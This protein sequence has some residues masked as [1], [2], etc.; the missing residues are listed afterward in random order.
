M[1]ITI[2]NLPADFRLQLSCLDTAGNT[3]GTPLLLYAEPI[4]GE[5]PQIDTRK[6][7]NDKI[8]LSLQGDITPNRNWVT[9]DSNQQWVDMEGDIVK[10]DIIT[11]KTTRSS[12]RRALQTRM[13]GQSQAI[14]ARASRVRWLCTIQ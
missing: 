11:A 1:K 6:D 14:L 4:P 2:P 3:Q 13:H 7:A 10:F 8:R 12:G 9:I 5:P